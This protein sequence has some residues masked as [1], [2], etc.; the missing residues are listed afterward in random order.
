[1]W[2]E[3]AHPDVYLQTEHI[4]GSP[5]DTLSFSGTA[6]DYCIAYRSGPEFGQAVL[7]VDNQTVGIGQN[8]PGDT[9]TK[10]T[11]C[12]H[13]E[14]AAPRTAKLTVSSGTVNVDA[15]WVQTTP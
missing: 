14:T 4:S 7:T 3:Q 9:G 12:V 6:T 2:K 1:M 15:F 8:F 13:M 11:R 5:L 10:E